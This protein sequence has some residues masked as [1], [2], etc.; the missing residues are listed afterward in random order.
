MQQQQQQQ[1]AQTMRKRYQTKRQQQNQVCFFLFFW[2]FVFMCLIGF[3]FKDNENESPVRKALRERLSLVVEQNTNA[4]YFF[5]S[6]LFFIDIEEIG[7]AWDCD[8]QSTA[9]ARA[10]AWTRSSR[11]DCCIV[12]FVHSF[13]HFDS[14]HQIYLCS[15]CIDGWVLCAHSDDCAHRDTTKPPSRLIEMIW[16]RLI[17]G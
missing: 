8:S 17:N 6:S 10:A 7:K 15:I 5:F 9:G 12:S 11:L 14:I 4:L 2:G 1:V 3:L 13:I 16:L